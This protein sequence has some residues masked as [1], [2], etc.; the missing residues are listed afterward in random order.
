MRTIA[1]AD[2]WLNFN[3]LM[4]MLAALRAQLKEEVYNRLFCYGYVH[5]TEIAN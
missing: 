4:H 2:A 5:P 3:A 1:Y